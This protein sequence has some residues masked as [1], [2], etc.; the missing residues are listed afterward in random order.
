MKPVADGSGLL[1]VSVEGETA[2]FHDS[3]RAGDRGEGVGD[4]AGDPLVGSKVFDQGLCAFGCEAS[5]LEGRQDGVADL[6]LCGR[7]RKRAEGSDQ[8]AGAVRVREG[9]VAVPA[10][11]LRMLFE[12]RQYEVEDVWLPIDGR[13][14][15]GDRA[16]N[17]FAETLVVGLLGLHC[18]WGNGDKRKVGR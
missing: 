6:A 9:Y 3:D 4:D 15:R 11:L 2:L 7:P 13:P 8:S 14:V 5:A 16:L 1:A 18:F 17:Q 10:D 12:L